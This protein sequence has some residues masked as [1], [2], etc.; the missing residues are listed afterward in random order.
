M[1]SSIMYR[2]IYLKIH[3]Q[4]NEQINLFLLGMISSKK[5]CQQFDV[6]YKLLVQYATEV[7]I[8]YECLVYWKPCIL[9]HPLARLKNGQSKR[10]CSRVS[11]ATLYTLYI[12]ETVS[13]KWQ[14]Q[15]TVTMCLV[16]ARATNVASLQCTWQYILWSVGCDRILWRCQ[17]DSPSWSTDFSDFF[18]QHWYTIIQW[19]LNVWKCRPIADVVSLTFWSAVSLF[20]ILKRLGI[21]CKKN[22]LFL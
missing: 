10:M 18:L 2:L 12:G 4:R 13:W 7:W 1:I 15:E 20:R 16:L 19:T 6:S 17:L 8:A 14:S 22:Y 21:H 9:D 11:I 5:S 3:I